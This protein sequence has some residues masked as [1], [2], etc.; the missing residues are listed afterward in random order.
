MNITISTAKTVV[1]RFAGRAG[2]QITKHLPEILTGLGIAGGIATVVTAAKST[3]ELQDN[4]AEGV[5]LVEGHKKLREEKSEDE[6]SKATYAKDMLISYS[7]VATGVIK[8]YAIP[9]AF[10]MASVTAILGAVG[11]LKKRNAAITAAYNLLDASYRAYKKRVVDE[12]GEETEAKI[13][14]RYKA[15]TTDADTSDEKTG[16]ESLCELAK[17]LRGREAE[18]KPSPYAAFFSRSNANW[19]ITLEDALWFVECVEKFMND[20]LT[21]KGHLFLNDV[22]RAL[23]LPDT[24]AGAVTGWVKTAGCGDGFVDLG[25]DKLRKQ[26]DSPFGHDMQD[27][28]WVEFNVDGVIYDM[29][30]G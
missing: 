11:I 26:M 2:L 4:I 20:K 3:L 9:A 6:Y 1:T 27:G 15:P 23:G 16:D 12:V 19:D 17:K 5:R 10:G 29:I 13:S 18:G 14:G 8:T 7:R 30:G 21:S 25:L 28:F 22:Y 24:K